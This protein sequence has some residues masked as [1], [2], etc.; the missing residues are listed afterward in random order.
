MSIMVGVGRGAT[1]GVL[2]KSA[3]AL[4]R[5]EKVDTLVVDKTGTLTEGKPRVIAVQPAP[6][7]GEA[8]VLVLA[9]SLEQSSEHPLG[10]AIIA[11]ARERSLP[12][13]DVEGFASVTGQGVRGAVEGHAVAVGNASSMQALGVTLGE[14]AATAEALRHDGA[15]ALFL[16]LDGAP[17]GVI[18]IADP[19]KPGAAAALQRLRNE[20]IRIVMLTGDNRT[21]AA[22]VAG[23]LGI[24]EVE[25]EVLP[26][27][28]HRIVTRLRAEGRVVAMAGDGINDAPAFA[29]ADVGIAMGTGTDVAMQSAG[30][31]LVK[32]DLAGIARARAL[33]RATMR[34][35]RQNLA[36]A[37]V[38]NA[39]GIP[40][41]AGVLYPSFG[42]LLSPIVAAL[43][44]SLSSVSVIA[45]A[46]RLRRPRWDGGASGE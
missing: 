13:R 37:F 43:A 46:L 35:I 28:K 11:A 40:I 39:V 27:E 23:Q 15:T 38:Y 7:R 4:E 34:N 32:G 12:L 5:L 3:E 9:A 18:A 31:T 8:E 10:A 2:I 45:N 19:I 20:N 21:T 14:L 24:T 16:A 22:S 25:A 42:L 36:L 26:E 17:A 6:G 33:S 29:A 30:I 44:M 41:A 1:E